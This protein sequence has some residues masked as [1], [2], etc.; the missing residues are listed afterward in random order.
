MGQSRLAV[1]AWDKI[2]ARTSAI[3]K[4]INTMT[5][6]VDMSSYPLKQTS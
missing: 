6:W 3:K 4:L 2:F 5:A 1:S